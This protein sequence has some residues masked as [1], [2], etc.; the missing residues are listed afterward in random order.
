LAPHEVVL[1]EHRFDLA[2]MGVLVLVAELDLLAIR[3][4]DDRN[5]ELIGIAPAL[6][7]AAAQGDAGAFCFENSDRAALPVEQRIIGLAAVIKG[8]FEPHTAAVGE[9]ATRIPEE[10]VNFDAGEGFVGHAN[11]PERTQARPVP[12]DGSQNDSETAPDAAK[13]AATLICG[14]P[15]GYL[16]SIKCAYPIPK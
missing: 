7:L 8:I 3:Q 6:R 16:T 11:R 9:P 14:I 13:P 1:A 15:R 10:L 5:A 2:E 4:E 12:T